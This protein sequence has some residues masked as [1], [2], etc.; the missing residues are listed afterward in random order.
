MQLHFR[1]SRTRGLSVYAAAACEEEVLSGRWFT[2][3]ANAQIQGTEVIVNRTLAD[4][5]LRD[6]SVPTAEDIGCVHPEALTHSKGT[7][8]SQKENRK[9]RWGK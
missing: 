2:L 6:P 1:W 5:L 9:R 3:K 7:D 8:S 4:L